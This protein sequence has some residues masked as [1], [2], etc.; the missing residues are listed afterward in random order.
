[1]RSDG[2]IGKRL[3][4]KTLQM[5]AMLSALFF[6]SALASFAQNQFDKRRIDNIEIT[7]G[8]SRR[9]NSLVEQYKLIARD[10]LGTIYSTPRIRD[11]IEALYA[12]RAI[13]TITVSAQMN[14]AGGVDLSYD[15]KRKTQAQ[16]VDVTVENAPG[17]NIT[18]EDILF[19]LN[20][21]DPGTAITE[22][23]LKDNADEI[24]DYMRE[25]GYYKAE[26]SYEQRKLASDNEIGVT[27]RVVLNPQST[28]E[29]F[30]INIEGLTTPIEPRRLKLDTGDRYSRDRLTAALQ[31][32]RNRLKKDK[33][34]APQLNEPRVTYDSDTNTVA[35]ELTGKAGPTVEMNIETDKGPGK[36]KE[37]TQIDL[38]P[39]LRDGT[40]DYSAIV[41][42]ERRLENRYQEQGYF[43]A[44]V[45]PVCS[46]TPPISDIENNP[47]QNG[48]NFL[49]S[50]LGSEDLMGRAVEIRYAVKLDRRLTLREIRVQGTDKLTYEDIKTVLRSQPANALGFIPILGYGNGYTSAAVLEED[51]S[52][53][54]SLMW[55]LGYRDAQVRVNQGVSPAGDDLIITFVVEEGIPSVVTDVSILGNSAIPTA[56]LEARLPA[57]AG[58]HYSRARVRNAVRSLAE[59]Y[60]DHG[61]YNARVVS[62]LIETPPTAGAVQRDVGIELVI[63]NEGKRV[64]INE[65]LIAGNDKTNEKAI[66]R[67]LTLQKGGLLKAGDIYTSE[68]NLYGSDVFSRVDIKAQP[69]GD[70][71]P[72]ERLSN[73]I[74]NVE[75]QPSRLMTYG[76][77]YSTDTGLNGFFDIRHQNLFGNLWQGGFRIKV[78]QR[79]QLIRFD[80]V[81]PRFMRD[82]AKRFS[83]LTLSLQYQRDTTVTRFFRSAFDQGTF[84]IVQRVDPKG[85]AIDEFGRATGSPTL[86]KLAFYAETSRTIN[87]KSRSLLFLRYRFEDVRLFKINSLLIKDLLVPDA[88]TRISGFGVT[89][90]RDTRENCSQKQSLLDLI[91]KG[92]PSAPC[93]YNASDPTRGSFLTAEYNVSLP[94]LGANV[95]FHKMQASANFYYTVGRLRQTTFA[96]RAIVGA[97]Q[98]FAG[99]NRFTN[100]AFPSL[101][102]LLPISERFFG[103]GSNSLRGFKYEVAG[104]R[105]AIMPTGTFRNSKGNQVF[106]D[107]FTVPF[108]GNAIAVVNLEARVGISP[109]FRVVPFYDGGNVFRR[110]GDIFKAK[111]V[112]AN[113]V[114]LVNQRALW[115]HTF[116]LGLRLKLPVGGEFGV[117]YGRMINPPRFLIPQQ[118]GP[119]AIYQLRKDQIHFRFSQAF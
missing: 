44:D 94:F 65:V 21:L 31:E 22:Q 13:D 10:A 71:G 27:F 11:S 70:A 7:F 85:K 35:I 45:T 25:R 41:E 18:R 73:V 81:H 28:V 20:L 23:T 109:S 34:L 106:L 77:G 104:P 111:P 84:G 105:V 103:G 56:E 72:D 17:D 90:A 6:L 3:K 42:G 116:G 37:A 63:E 82:G 32:V 83:P 92:E 39:V 112:P 119:N 78:S 14:A 108:G 89:F 19:K 38:F 67:A 88:R 95:G 36:T 33:F 118:S 57:L 64:R 107:P 43:F 115:T 96:A 53:V 15:I 66:R 101:N 40:L 113:N 100:A 59:Y 47:V 16:R 75:E 1:M 110:P 86:N 9:S 76:G 114:E 117:D 51:L 69:A 60:S 79:Q 4:T 97:G 52:T 87:R 91:A 55:E 8:A 29:R 24:L 80:F 99:G 49:C 68:Q 5:A 62:K 93:R 26:V 54:K 2:G 50:L 46:V 61:Y 102:G 30:A 98:V 12:T 48:T 58:R 74:V